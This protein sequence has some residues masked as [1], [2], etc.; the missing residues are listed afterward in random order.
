LCDSAVHDYTK[1]EG[2]YT[3]M[4]VEG[5]GMQSRIKLKTNK[6]EEVNFKHEEKKKVLN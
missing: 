4:S 1:E 3:R 6:N 5:T 2:C